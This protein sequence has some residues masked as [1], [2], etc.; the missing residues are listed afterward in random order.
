[1]SKF[2]IAEKEYLDPEGSDLPYCQDCGEE[3]CYCTCEEYT[4]EINN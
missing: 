3:W 4:N 1:M 2:E